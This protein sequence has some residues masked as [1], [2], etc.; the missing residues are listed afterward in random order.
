[1]PTNRSAR[2][3]AEPLNHGREHREGAVEAGP[4]RQPV[5]RAS[6]ELAARGV[7]RLIHATHFRNLPQIFEEGELLPRTV[8]LQRKLRSIMP[9]D[10][11]LDR[12]P[13]CVSASIEFPN[14]Y[15]MEDSSNKAGHSF[16]M[17]DWALLALQPTIVDRGGTLFHP[18]NAAR[19]SGR[20]GD[21]N[22]VGRL[23]ASPSP[24]TGIERSVTHLPESPT[25]LQ[26]EVQL[27][28][29][30]ATEDIIAVIG[31]SAPIVEGWRDSYRHLKHS[32]HIRWGYSRMLFDRTM[33]SSWI[34]GGSRPNESWLSE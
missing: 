7:T 23:W 11:R 2:R 10:R 27:P 4:G 25:D 21:P 13:D 16:P 3:S 14:V 12:R 22:A 29:T 28:D 24:V 5:A 6:R 15:F 19:D 17:R 20:H 31:I 26:A 33:L 34:A 1:M 30:V 18:C 9:D 32:S 8:V